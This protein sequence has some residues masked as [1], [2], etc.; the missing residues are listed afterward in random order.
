[1]CSLTTGPARTYDRR[2]DPGNQQRKPTAARAR[3]G[4]PAWGHLLP[5]PAAP[6]GTTRTDFR[7]LEAGVRPPLQ[8]P[9]E[10]HGAIQ[11]VRVLGSWFGI[12]CLGFTL[13]P[14]CYTIYTPYIPNI[15]VK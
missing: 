8:P 10:T 6:R 13:D 5:T 3:R 4:G 1:M 14:R 12:E 9:A 7:A 15:A 11:G 2:A